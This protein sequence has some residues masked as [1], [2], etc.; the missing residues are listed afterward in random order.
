MLFEI[1][2]LFICF[3]LHSNRVTGIYELSLCK[4]ADTGSPGKLCGS[5]KG[6]LPLHLTAV[7]Y[8]KSLSHPCRM[9]IHSWDTSYILQATLVVVVGVTISELQHCL[10]Y[11][12]LYSYKNCIEQIVTRLWNII[13][14]TNSSILWEFPGDPVVRTQCIH[15]H[16]P[17]FSPWSRK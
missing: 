15:C 8:I 12:V 14:I 10:L 17:R 3:N 13:S 7:H 6:E 1:K 5:G 2:Q 9:D 11:D 16:G 4:M